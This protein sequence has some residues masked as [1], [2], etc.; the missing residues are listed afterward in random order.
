MELQ[1]HSDEFHSKKNGKMKK[2]VSRRKFLHFM[3]WA[4]A[5]AFLGWRHPD[6][7][8]KPKAGIIPGSAIPVLPGRLVHV[9]DADATNWDFSTG[10]YG[11]HVDQQV[12]DD[13][14]E[15]GLL[16]LT[17]TKNVASAWKRLV[18]NFVP[19]QTFAVK[20]N[21]ACFNQGGPDPDPDINALIEPVNSLIG[22]LIQFGA[23]PEDISVYD[24]T[25][26]GGHN[27][28]MPQISFINR[29]LYP[30]VNFVYTYGNP[31][32]FSSTQYVQFNAPGYPGIPDLRVCN[33]LVDSDY[34]INM[35]IPKAHSAAGITMGF[36]NHLGSHEKALKVHEYLPYS[37]YYNPEYSP[38]V[39]TFKNPH[40]ANKTVLTI[41]D[42]LFGNWKALSG[43]PRR[44]LTFGNEAM[45]SLFFSADPVCSDAVLTDFVEI[46][47][48]QQ[49]YGKLMDGTRDYLSLAQQEKFGINDQGDPWKLPMGSDYKRLK[50]IYIDGV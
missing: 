30:G 43:A 49:G 36:K 48:M 39:A 9:H 44:W 42:G 27:G 40:F 47:R 20:V 10:W 23:A 17:R 4:G 13:M 29:C 25:S 5:G 3:Q 11:Y 38:F 28:S 34:L 21:F 12:V 1:M 16:A 8:M 35:Y 31:D 45:N 33:A 41:A 24:V 18:P 14:T 26:G 6:G 32:P 22:T 19:G 50:Y 2:G 46:E 37:Y 7:P 15:A